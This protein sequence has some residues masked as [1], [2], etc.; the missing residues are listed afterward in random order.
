MATPLVLP[1]LVGLAARPVLGKL[2]KPVTRGMVKSYVVLAVEVKKAAARAGAE[3]QEL[4]VEMDKEMPLAENVDV[5]PP[6][7][8]KTGK[9]T[10]PTR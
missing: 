4:A 8:M 9:P 3:L 6:G 7:P 2:V 1:F 5:V 10:T